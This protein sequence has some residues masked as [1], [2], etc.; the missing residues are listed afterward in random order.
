MKQIL[1]LVVL[2]LGLALCA[3]MRPAA[4]SR[5]LS[6]QDLIG[7]TVE[8]RDGELAGSLA[9]LLVAPASG[10][11]EYGVVK[12]APGPLQFG[13]MPLHSPPNRVLSPWR[14]IA[15]AQSEYGT[16][17]VVDSSI[18]TIR[19]APALPGTLNADQ[20]GWDAAQV[21]YWSSPNP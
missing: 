2:G 17:L 16:H 4:A 3:C 13:K 7:L 20:P 8:S 18:G 6:S 1:S 12:L 10:Q 11:I 21:K 15:I 9:N 14:L 19:N 5:E